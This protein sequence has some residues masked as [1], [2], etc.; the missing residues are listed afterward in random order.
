MTHFSK[1]PTVVTVESVTLKKV[2]ATP[3]SDLKLIPR[4]LREYA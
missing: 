1:M 2:T 4:V 3:S